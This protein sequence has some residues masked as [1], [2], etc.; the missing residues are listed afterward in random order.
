MMRRPRLRTVLRWGAIAVFVA[1]IGTAVGVAVTPLVK[2]DRAT[3]ASRLCLAREK[4]PRGPGFP[5]CGAMIREF[6]QLAGTWYTNHDATYRAEELWARIMMGLYENAAVGDP[7]PA[8]LTRTSKFVG[9]AEDVLDRGSRRLSLDDLG[10]S[11][12]APKQGVMAALVGDRRT[13]TAQTDHWN[14]W[15]IRLRAIQA[16]LVEARLPDAIDIAK[17]YAK[18][19]PHEADLRTEIGAVLCLGPSPE[20]GLD[21]LAGVPSDRAEHRHAAMAR[22]YGEVLSVMVACSK[23]AKLPPPPMPSGSAGSADVE[24]TRAVEDIRVEDDVKLLAIAL[25]RAETMLTDEAGIVDPATPFARAYLVAALALRDA[26]APRDAKT[27]G[28][29][30]RTVPAALYD[31]VSPRGSEGA[32]GPDPRDVLALSLDEGPGVHPMLSPEA[33]MKASDNLV[34]I[35]EEPDPKPAPS[36][37]KEHAPPVIELRAT[38]L[39]RG[40]APKDRDATDAIDDM[41]PPKPPAPPPPFDVR[42]ARLRKAAGSIAL[43]AGI[44]A[45]RQGKG[46]VAAK[47]LTRT[48]EL[49]E[50]DAG[51]ANLLLGV[52]AYVAGSEAS[53]AAFLDP[54]YIDGPDTRVRVTCAIVRALALAASGDRE[55]ARASVDLAKELAGKADDGAKG[56]SDTEREALRLDVAWVDLALSQARAVDGANAFPTNTGQADPS[57]RWETRGA[58]PIARNFAAWTNALADSAPNRLAFRYA[59]VDARGDAPNGLTPYLVAGGRLLDEGTRGPSV[60]VWLDALTADDVPRRSASGYAFARREA[61][62]IRGDEAS[63]TLWNDRLRAL[64]ALSAAPETFEIARFLDL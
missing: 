51:T 18:D 28:R 11:V 2:V 3:R 47:A 36:A 22:N 59:L 6:E 20:A 17:R 32:F 35:A 7:D 46:D 56:A 30:S 42:R 44:V 38:I 19:E 52:S 1:A 49:L 57:L 60:E 58:D 5:E 26:D 39:D 23:H 45:T 48:S 15:T 41:P 10:P 27:D 34:R 53:A 9:D 40:A 16:A 33:L 55:G 37:K 54:K 14:L 8:E 21:V 63:A 50:L 29:P 12:G 64:R 43:L 25:D 62:H 31:L 61:A 4:A 13:L 24:A